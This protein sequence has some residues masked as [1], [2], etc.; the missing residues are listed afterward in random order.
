MCLLRTDDNV[1]RS[2][3]QPSLVLVEGQVIGSDFPHLTGEPGRMEREDRITACCDDNVPHVIGQMQRILQQPGAAV[4][5]Q[6]MD[7][8]DDQRDGLETQGIR[9]P[10]P[11]LPAIRG[12]HRVQPDHRTAGVWS[13]LLQQRGLA[14][15]RGGGHERN[16][17]RS[18]ATELQKPSTSDHA[19]LRDRHPSAAR[20]FA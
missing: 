2:Q 7:V 11:Q 17:L 18:A 13:P 3:E 4:A 16:R 6:E 5:L 15:A 10:T 9:D 8:V 1:V 19:V 12:L 14:I 20:P